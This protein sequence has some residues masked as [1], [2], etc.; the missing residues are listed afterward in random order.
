M[1]KSFLERVI[2]S[3]TEKL[4]T[5]LNKPKAENSRDALAMMLYSS[6]FDWLVAKINSSLQEDS[7]SSSASSSTSSLASYFSMGKEK[8]VSSMNTSS[9]SFIGLLDIYGFES[10]ETNGFPQF[11]IN[12]ANEKLQVRNI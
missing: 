10:F 9:S 8:R 3:G 1:A 11:C 2:T 12:Y 7:T 5:P 6:L 4:T